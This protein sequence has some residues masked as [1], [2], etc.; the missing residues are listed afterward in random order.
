MSNIEKYKS[1]ICKN[2]INIRKALVL[3]NTNKLKCLIV[4]DSKKRLVGTLTDGDIRRSLLKGAKFNDGI[5]KHV[6]RNSFSINKS[7]FTQ[8]KNFDIPTDIALIPIIDSKKKVVNLIRNN[9]FINNKIS[10]SQLST[11]V[12]IMAGGLGTRLRPFSSIIPKPLIPIEGKPIIE[13][14]MDKFIQNN[15]KKFIIS[16]NINHKIVKA[17]FKTSKKKYELKYIS[18]KKTLGTVGS[19]SL[20]KNISKDFFVINCDSILDFNYKSA[21]EYHQINKN[22]LTVIVAKKKIEIPYGVFEFDKYDKIQIIE[23]PS[24]E[25]LINTGM[26]VFS[27]KILTFLKKNK[28]I[29]MDELIK[30]VISKK[31][32][33]NLFPIENISWYDF[34]QLGSFFQNKKNLIKFKK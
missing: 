25:I 32:K 23:K 28:K 19:L 7:K 21:L 8:N 9:K 16:I 13:H 11:Q 18:E 14:I 3:L 22:D 24:K 2:N 33:V 15:F 31:L 26:Y 6:Y 20:V 27:K 10:D 12:I 5:N 4:I 1:N 34:G 30:K 29:D 17:F